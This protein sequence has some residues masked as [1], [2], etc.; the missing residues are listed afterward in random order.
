VG[1]H[2]AEGLLLVGD[3]ADALAQ[4]ADLLRAEPQALDEVAVRAPLV[5]LGHVGGVGRHDALLP[6]LYRFRYL[7]QDLLPLLRRFVGVSV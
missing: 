5:G 1:G 4:V 3:G 6:G 7:Y 2:L